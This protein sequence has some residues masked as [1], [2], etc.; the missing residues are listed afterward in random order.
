MR[1]EI[2]TEFCQYL[3]GCRGWEVTPGEFDQSFKILLEI[4]RINLK[5][6][7]I[8]IINVGIGAVKVKYINNWKNLGEK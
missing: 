7:L 1:T 6:N 2:R 3:R 8:I 4:W 5:P